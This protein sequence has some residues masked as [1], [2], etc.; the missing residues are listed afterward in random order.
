MTGFFD[1]LGQFWAD[2]F[3][4]LLGCEITIGAFTTNL[5]FVLFA[6]LAVGIVI[7]VYWGGSK[8]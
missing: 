6:F 3:N 1:L 4:L 5:F 2:I 8:A 7:T